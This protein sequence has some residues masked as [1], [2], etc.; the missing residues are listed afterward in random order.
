MGD[1]DTGAGFQLHFAK[2]DRTA[3]GI[4]SR[5]L[6]GGH[7]LFHIKESAHVCLVVSFVVEPSLDFMQD[8]DFI[9]FGFGDCD[10]GVLS[11]SENTVPVREKQG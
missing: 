5:S 8:V 3:P 11:F 6:G 4:V 9:G 7:M 2:T 1:H 10:E